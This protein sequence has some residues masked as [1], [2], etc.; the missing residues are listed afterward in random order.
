MSHRRSQPKELGVLIGPPEQRLHA[1][2]RIS[3]KNAGLA[4]RKAFFM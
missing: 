3:K 2:T 1:A 4:Q